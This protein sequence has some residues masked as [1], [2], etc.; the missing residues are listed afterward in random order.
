MG[1]VPE[2]ANAYI[3]L[4]PL[5]NLLLMGELYGIPKKEKKRKSRTIITFG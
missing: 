4:S 3:D 5:K 2:M 1:I